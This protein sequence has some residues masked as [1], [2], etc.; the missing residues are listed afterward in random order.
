MI[1]ESMKLRLLS[2]A[3]LASASSAFAQLNG[4]GY[5]RIQNYGTERWL[6]LIDNKS[7]GVNWSSTTAEVAAIL[8]SDDAERK[9]YDP[10]GIVYVQNAGGTSYDFKAQ[11]ESIKEISG[12]HYLNVSDANSSLST[13]YC[14]FTSNGASVYLWDDTWAGVS[15]E[16]H[17][18]TSKQNSTTMRQWQ[19]FAV[20][21]SDDNN[22]FGIKPDVEIDGKYYKAFYAAFPF[23]VKS[24][25]MAVYY[26]SELINLNTAVTVV[27]ADDN[28]VIP[29]ST[30]VFIECTSSDYSNNRIDIVD[31]S[32][33]TLSSNILSGNYFC[34]NDQWYP[35]HK[36]VLVNNT[37][38][39]RVLGKM[40]NGL[41]GYIT[42]SDTYIPA[43][44]S[45]LV[46]PEGSPSELPLSGAIT[47]ISNVKVDTPASS[48]NA[49]YSLQGVKVA[50]SLSSAS[51]T[52]GIYIV[53]GKKVVVK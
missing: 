38:T 37:A 52:P 20:N 49:V 17:A 23:K 27:K 6:Y 50:D 41:L 22:Y 33:T 45:Y 7:D 46:V 13:Y 40:S 1:I 39:M 2:L 47:G 32:G 48:S 25:G 42:S 30:P 53:G 11:G 10:A 34:Y 43:N 12:G 16:S 29:A 35:N 19:A 24:S 26:A 21:S 9:F 31:E 18:T 3:L 36:N 8:L 5:Y 44:S 4:D 28:A 51:L 14:S 15:T